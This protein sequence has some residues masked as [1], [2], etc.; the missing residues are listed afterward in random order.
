VNRRDFLRLGV[1]GGAATA[2]AP[3]LP[4]LAAGDGG[5]YGPLLPPDANGLML[6]EEFTAREIARAGEPVGASAY[7]WHR[8]PDGG[9][10][11]EAKGRGW[12]YVSNSEAGRPDAGASASTFDRKG[13][14]L[15]AYRILGGTQLNCAGG[16]TPWGT[17]LSCEEHPT[18]QVWECD[19]TGAEAAVARPALGVFSHEAVAVDPK[20]RQLYLTEDQPNGRFYRFTPTEYPDLAAGELEVA[21]VDG[22]RVTWLAVPDPAAEAVPIREQVPESTE[23]NGGEGV[24]Y[25]AGVVYFTTKGDRKIWSYDARAE[26]LETLYDAAADDGSPVSSVD[27]LTMTPTGELLVAEDQPEEQELLL[28]TLDGQV[29]PLLRL[30]G[31]SGSELAGPAFAPNGKH[32]YLSSQRGGDGGITYVVT[33][34]FEKAKKKKKGKKNGDALG[35]PGPALALMAAGA[36]WRLRN[37]A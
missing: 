35:V 15:D 32:L 23:F 11:F 36:I 34:P 21:T 10:T 28:V 4:A 3:A 1:G 14:L 27:N 17:W 29:T 13:E 19:P 22:K 30:T 24:W 18:G 37:R 26:T 31:Q 8:F 2:L 20:R 12:I 6:P 9:A 33:G 25:H 16:P 5:D 7:P